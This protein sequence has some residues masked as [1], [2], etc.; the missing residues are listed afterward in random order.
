M[1]SIPA[2]PGD[3]LL[4]KFRSLA[5][6]QHVEFVA[7]I[8]LNHRLFAADPRSFNDPFDCVAHYSFDAT[9]TERIDR[10]VAWL[11][12][13]NPSIGDDEARRHAPVLCREVEANG[14]ARFRS[15]VEEDLGVVSLAATVDNL[16]LWAHYASSHTG[17][18]IE[19]HASDLTHG[20]FFG[21][22]LPVAYQVDLPVVDVY[23]DEP[24]D[25]VRKILLTKSEDWAYEREWR[26][27]VTNRSAQTYV[28][29]DP[30]LVHAVYLGCK[31]A[32]DKRDI[33]RQWLSDRSCSPAPKIL[34]ARQSDTQYGLVFD[35]LVQ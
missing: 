17:I 18:A 33:V 28:C 30:R 10:A 21:D 31:I 13:K 24:T 35:E 3:T 12:K 1:D 22:A 34:Q 20:K 9:E 14:P 29:F 27:T 7:D 26:I 15:H 5:T 19:F 4:Y 8:L 11:R 25:Q 23:R 16:L 32:D 2:I 6:N